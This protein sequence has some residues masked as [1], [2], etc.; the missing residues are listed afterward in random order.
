MAQFTKL[1][2]EPLVQAAV[3][4]SPGSQWP[5]L[6]LLDGL[7]KCIGNND[8][9]EKKC[10]IIKVIYASL[11][12]FDISLQFL[13]AS[14]SEPHI[15]NIFKRPDILSISHYLELDDSFDPDQDIGIFLHAEFFHIRAYHSLMASVTKWPSETVLGHLVAK[16]SQQFIYAAT[17]IKF[18][19]DP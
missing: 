5:T 11:A 1:I 16:S 10:A 19:G 2:A 13:I 4:D 18:V 17:V 6:I 12:G 15:R 14:C 8:G 9:E 3:M 7:D